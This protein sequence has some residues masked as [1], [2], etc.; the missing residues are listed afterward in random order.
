MKKVKLFRAIES[1]GAG[2]GFD[3]VENAAFQR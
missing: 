3:S 2:D 1:I